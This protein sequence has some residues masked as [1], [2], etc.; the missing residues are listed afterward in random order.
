MEAIYLE[1]LCFTT[2]GLIF[3]HSLSMKEI[4]IQEQLCMPQEP[5]EIICWPFV[6]VPVAK[7]A[8]AHVL[9][10]IHKGVSTS[11]NFT[12]CN[13]KKCIYC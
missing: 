2:S 5:L 10:L 13:F 1:I 3:Q 8:P 11:C 9:R 7:P 12:F 6:I 4:L